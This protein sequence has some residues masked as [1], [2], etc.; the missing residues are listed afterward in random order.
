MKGLIIR[1]LRKSACLVASFRCGRSRINT[2]GFTLV[3]L[4][5]V[6]GIIAILFAL[7]FPAVRS[8]STGAKRSHAA[9]DVQRIVVAV[10][11]FELEYGRLPFLDVTREAEEGEDIAV[12]DR[13]AGI[14]IPNR[15]LF[16]V[17]RAIPRGT[18]RDDSIN[19]RRVVFLD[20]QDV[21]NPHQPAS[22]FLSQSG[23]SSADTDCFFDP[24]GKQYCVALDYSGDHK[25][26]VGYVDFIGANEPEVSAA[27]F[28]LGAD[29]KL[30]HK[31]NQAYRKGG[32]ISD[33]IIS[34]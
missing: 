16:Y 18:N 3:E 4:L 8:V 2:R 33:D 10:K 22:G 27:A 6:V 17:L 30:G 28:S 24:W 25:T 32:T 19:F 34:W 26:K 5:V 9:A 12:G 21:K 1:R 29:S 14:T 15:D 7:T 20:G 31:G 23:V 11:S 13:C